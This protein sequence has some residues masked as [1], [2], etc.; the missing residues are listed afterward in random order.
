MLTDDEVKKIQEL[1]ERGYAK[2]R[3]AKTLGVSRG[4]VSKY[5]GERGEHLSLAALKKRFDEC[6]RWAA[7]PFCKLMY[8]AP[9][10]LPGWQCPGCKRS[11]SWPEPHFK[12]RSK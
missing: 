9:K 10:F 4:T 7:C 1:K 8:W 12:Q 3:V 2:A 11:Y 6:F 5:W